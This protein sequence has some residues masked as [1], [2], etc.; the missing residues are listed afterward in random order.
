M[1]SGAGGIQTHVIPGNPCGGAGAVLDPLERG[2]A[3]GEVHGLVDVCG[4]LVSAGGSLAAGG[5]EERMAADDFRDPEWLAVV[6]IDW[7]GR[8]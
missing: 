2:L 5:V 6:R 8:R 1:K 7:R 4:D 3:G